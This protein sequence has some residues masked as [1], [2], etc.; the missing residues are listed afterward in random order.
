ML[1]AVVQEA[2]RVT[3]ERTEMGL[4]AKVIT[5]AMVGSAGLVRQLQ[6]AEAVLAGWV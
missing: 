4:L 6:A 2:A 1:V 5:A 3:R